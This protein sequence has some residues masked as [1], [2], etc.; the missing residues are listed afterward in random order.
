MKEKRKLQHPKIT[1]NPPQVCN[2]ANKRR[3]K[4]R[5][6]MRLAHLPVPS[7]SLSLSLSTGLTDRGLYRKPS[8]SDWSALHVPRPPL[9]LSLSLTIPRYREGGGRGACLFLSRAQE[10]V[11]ALFQRNASHAVD[12]PSPPL[13]IYT[14]ASLSTYT[15]L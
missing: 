4:K 7:F 13:R 12:V 1:S 3:E 6:C 14:Q 10:P 9:S 11:S 8:L 15:V 5:H 2:Q